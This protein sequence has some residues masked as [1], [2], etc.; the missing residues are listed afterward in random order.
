A[1]VSKQFTAAAVLL[2]AQEGKL[3]LDDLASRWLPS[4][5][6]ATRAV[7][8]RHLLT[9]SSGVLDYEDLMAPDATAQVHDADVLRLLEGEDRLYFAPGSGYRYS[10]SGCALLALV[11][12]RASGERFADFL[13][14]RIFE[15]LGMTAVAHEEGVSTVPHRAYGYSLEQGR[16][17]RTDQSSTSA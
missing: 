9:H 2:L 14:T 13:R 11:V 3:S 5:P 4:L 17:V 12:E 6:P 1:S 10:N 7:T 16:W 8:L 15:P